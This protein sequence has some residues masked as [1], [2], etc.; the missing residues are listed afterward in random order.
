[1]PIKI[2]DNLP[3]RA[4]L[5]K[6]RIQ[7]IG[8]GRA[9]HQDI[10]PLEIAILNLMPNKVATETQLLR[11]LG[12]TPLQVNITL[13][14]TA[15]H[16]SKNTSS[17]HI[18]KN[19]ES[20]QDVK[21]KQFD[22]L[23]VTGAP[24]EYLAFEDVD[25]W[26]E[27]TEIFDWAKKNVFARFFLCWGA[28]AYLYHFYNIEKHKADTKIFGVFKAETHDI[29]HPLTQ[30]FDDSFNV[31]AARLTYT[32]ISDMQAIDG[33][34]TLATTQGGEACLL[35]NDITRDTYMFNHLEY[36]SD[37]LKAEYD[38]DKDVRDDI[39]LPVNYFPQDDPEQK[40]LMRWRSH[41]YILFSNWINMLYQ[42]TPFDLSEIPLQ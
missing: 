15:S 18:L 40:P 31:P 36:D 1:M 16:K 3:A 28:Q 33:M 39:A 32:Q 38:R 4:V 29:F 27:L 5:E 14:H 12:F 21:D 30:G 7:V 2:P 6:E 26:Q 23:V 37:T 20:L 25:Y 22:G 41:R 9:T 35:H 19:Y 11:V 13:L 8:Q 17:D 42:G 10:R 34:K 24:I